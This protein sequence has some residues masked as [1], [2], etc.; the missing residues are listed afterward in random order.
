MEKVG[1]DRAVSVNLEHRPKKKSSF[2]N[3]WKSF[4]TRTMTVKDVELG[5]TTIVDNATPENTED[6]LSVRICKDVIR[7]NLI[8]NMRSLSGDVKILLDIEIGG[9]P[10]L[11]RE[12]KLTLNVLFLWSCFAKR[13]DLLPILFEKGA[14]LNCV[15]PSDGITPLHLSAFSGSTKCIKWLINQGCD[16]NPSTEQLSP[17]HYAV[18][19]NSPE[20]VKVLLGA[21]SI[22]SDT[23]L[24]YAARAGSAECLRMLLNQG[25]DPNT[26][27]HYGL[28][29]L[30]ISADKGNVQLVKLLLNIPKLG[31][32]I[33]TKEKGNTALHF[34]AE[35]GSVD[36]VELLLNKGANIFIKNIKGQIPLHLA[37]KSQSAECVD[38]LLKS[39]S[40]INAKD[41]ENR[42]PLHTAA[43]KELL[44]YHTVELLINVGADVNLKDKYGYTPLH[45]AAV[46]ELSHCVDLLIMNGADVS[47]RTKGGLTALSIVRRKTPASLATISKKL[48]SSISLHD[49]E[50]SYREVELKLDFRYLL[51]HSS[52]GEV[53]LLKTLIDEGQKSM[54]DHPLCC[55]FL[56]LKWQKIRR[57]YFTRLILSGIF[58]LFLTL[59]VMTSL[60]HNC[61]N[62]AHNTSTT[63]PE[64]CEKNSVVGRMLL[65]NSSI[66]EFIWYILV[67]FT[68][69]EISRKLFGIAGYS[70]ARQYFSMWANIIEWYTIIS[71]FVISYIYTGRTYIWQ[72][73]VGAFAVLCGWTNLMVIVG[74][75]PVFGT[76]VE[77]FTKVQA[78]FFKLFLA[79]S[80]L[81]IGFTISFCVIFPTAE[82]FQNPVIGFVKVLVMMTGELDIDLLLGEKGTGSSLP[83]HIS[84]HITFVLFLLFV[85]VVLMNLLVGIAV[86]D[87][88]GLHKTAGLSKLVRQ[89]ELISFL[90][91]SLF[92]GYLP[93]QIM[94]FLKWSA[95]MSPDAYRV[96][97]HVKPLNQREKRLPKNVM[98]E[99]LDIARQNRPCTSQRYINDVKPTSEQLTQ[100]IEKLELLLE[101]QKNMLAQILEKLNKN[102]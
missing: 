88:Q 35:S 25:A 3:K 12:N 42:T 31:I 91:L 75:L 60:A 43:G 29:P 94:K 5:V 51:Q 63:D 59:Y 33:P 39:G 13:D 21:G 71:V 89:T 86:H 9:Q 85:T 64:H 20:A 34:A 27:D 41:S 95:L 54:L 47:A 18:L 98:L 2:I 84:A 10:K 23:V 74:Q 4:R 78:E 102:T 38:L 58:V 82:S 99:A 16:L 83:L 15:L 37:S 76:Y 97:I 45:L 69:M 28:T 14:N 61:Y 68:I 100:K 65:D 17:L 93:K 44:A 79:Y 62:T 101:Q 96:V 67:V 57:F 30:H 1:L 11:K 24:H 46:N 49:P 40:D 48:D 19:G 6:E 56:H 70:S 22:L 55:A 26:L 77:M 8:D 52:G 72:N 36:I 50:Q 87:I 90:E 7:Q 53:G 81:L 66:M 80:C 92:Q 32:D 73:H